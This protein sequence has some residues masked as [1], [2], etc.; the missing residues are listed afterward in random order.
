MVFFTKTQ[1][2]VI[3]G[4]LSNYLF[5]SNIFSDK[6]HAMCHKIYNIRFKKI[7]HHFVFLLD[8]NK[9]KMYFLGYEIINNPLEDQINKDLMY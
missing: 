5:L 6:N 1:P 4:G 8:I 2:N 9:Y 3:Q 7:N